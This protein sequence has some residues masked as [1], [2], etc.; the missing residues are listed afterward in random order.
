[1]RSRKEWEPCLDVARV[2]RT[3]EGDRR[4]DVCWDQL[5]RNVCNRGSELFVACILVQRHEAAIQ[6]GV[7]KFHLCF[8]SFSNTPVPLFSCRHFVF[9]DDGS[10]LSRFLLRWHC[11][12]GAFIRIDFLFPCCCTAHSLCPIQTRLVLTRP[13]I[14]VAWLKPLHPSHL[15]VWFFQPCHHTHI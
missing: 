15:E 1:M 14:F 7:M 8:V 6:E 5:Q 9:L 3:R 13:C 11:C 12:V 2:L 4:V 10:V